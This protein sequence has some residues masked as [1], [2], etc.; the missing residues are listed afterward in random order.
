MIFYLLVGMCLAYEIHKI[1]DFKVFKRI[2]YFMYH[3]TEQV[4]QR[5]GKIQTVILKISLVELFYFGILIAGSFGSQWIFFGSLLVLSLISTTIL[6]NTKHKVYSVIYFIDIIL[7]SIILILALANFYFFKMESI[8][9]V[10][11][12]I[13]LI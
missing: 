6:K 10:K 13:S 11:Y 3:Y 12:L 1:L 5:K 8:D 4:K 2:T 7:S 9:F